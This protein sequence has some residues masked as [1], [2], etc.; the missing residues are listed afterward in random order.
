MTLLRRAAGRTEVDAEEA[1]VQLF[2]DHIDAERDQQL[3]RE[4]KCRLKAVPALAAERFRIDVERGVVRLAGAV[5]S[6]GVRQLAEY[7]AWRVAGVVDV[8]NEL[9]PSPRTR[10]TR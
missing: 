2:E 5:R 8:S 10:R 4:V 1:H 3:S 6:A 9:V 7:R